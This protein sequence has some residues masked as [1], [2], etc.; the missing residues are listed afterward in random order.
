MVS[1]SNLSSRPKTGGIL[2]RVI[3]PIG[4]KAGALKTSVQ[5]QALSQGTALGEMGSG[6]AGTKLVSEAENIVNPEVPSQAPVSAPE[7]KLPPGQTPTRPGFTQMA[8]QQ[9]EAA[10]ATR[11]PGQG[12]GGIAGALRTSREQAQERVAP[13]TGGI[14][15]SMRT[16]LE[17]AQENLVAQKALAE[18]GGTRS[19]NAV[20][21][22]SV[23][24]P[25]RPRFNRR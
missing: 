4:R 5:N 14:A 22:P 20:T 23:N 8:L 18:A 11:T 21:A 13:K 17:R 15:G 25:R 7:V 3:N 16:G 10:K 2:S 19:E 24:R 6:P 12:R 1:R 9:S